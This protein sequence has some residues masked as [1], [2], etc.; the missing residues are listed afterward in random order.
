MSYSSLNEC[1]KHRPYIFSK[2]VTKIV[3]P[4]VRVTVL[5]FFWFAR[6]ICKL[7]KWIFVN[8]VNKKL[9]ERVC[10]WFVHLQFVFFRV[11]NSSLVQTLKDIVTTDIK[12]Y[13]PFESIHTIVD[14]M[15]EVYTVEVQ[16]IFSQHT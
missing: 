7:N 6:F 2:P 13:K 12:Q 14:T 16:R 11:L 15:K 5:M 10:Y 8:G 3:T 1:A 4:L 9:L